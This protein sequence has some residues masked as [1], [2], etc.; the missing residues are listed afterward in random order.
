MRVRVG[1]F[2]S[3]FKRLMPAVSNKRGRMTQAEERRRDGACVLTVFV[4]VYTGNLLRK[5]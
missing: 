2:V 4:S 3:V 1:V 5:P